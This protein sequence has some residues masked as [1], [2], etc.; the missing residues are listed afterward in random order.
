MAKKSETAP[1]TARLQRSAIGALAIT[2]AGMRQLG[3]KAR[4]ITRSEEHKEQA[5]QEHEAELGRILFS[6]LNQ[7]KGT[8]LKVSQMLSMEA[9]LLPESI[10]AQLAKACYQVTPLNRAL[11]HKLFMREFGRAPQDLFAAFEAQACAAASLGQVHRARLHDGR[12]VALK[13][14]YPGIAASIAS[15]IAMLHGLLQTFGRHV[16]LLPQPEVMNQVMREIELK[17]NEEIDYQHEAAQLEWFAA[18]VRLPGI[19]LPRLVPQFSSRTVLC[20]EYLQGQ[21]LQEWLD[22]D[23][24][25]SA[26]DAVGQL[27]FDWFLYSTFEL[28]RVHADPHPG[29]FLILPDGRLGVLDFGCTRSLQPDFLLRLRHTWKLFLRL[30]ACSDAA[31]QRSWAEQL[32]AAYCSL[33]LVQ[34]RLDC[35]SYCEKIQPLL[36]PIQAWQAQ[37]F[38][39]A[40]ADGFFDF[41]QKAPY[42]A[43]NREAAEVMMAYLSEFDNDLMYFDR[44]YLGLMHLLTRLGARVKTRNRWLCTEEPAA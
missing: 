22:G 12:E 40:D 44:N 26:R 37:A 34:S 19:V 42:P 7:L 10:R 8:A 38:I 43:T 4:Q 20:M 41:S 18:H 1:P 29:N 27:L 30:Q 36:A 31:Q 35:A 24:P 21:H 16:S 23:P 11:V 3:H 2:R 5:Q 28:G 25:Q 14:Q 6:A 13:L 39:H 15:D 17:L 32:Y 33:G 9:G